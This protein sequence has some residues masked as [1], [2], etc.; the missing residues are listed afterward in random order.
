MTAPSSQD[1]VSPL[2]ANRTSPSVAVWLSGSSPAITQ[3]RSQIRRVAPH[4]RTALLTGERDC[5]ELAAAHILHQLSPRGHHPFRTLTAAD[6]EL[7]FGARTSPQSNSSPNPLPNTAEGMFY[8]PR[9]ERL[10]QAA[11]TGLLRL[12]RERG[13]QAPR[14]IAF[15][16]RGLRPLVTTD[17]FSP[18]LADALGALRIALPSLR[19][20]REDIPDLLTQMLQ[21]FAAQT[22]RTPPQLAPDLLDAAMKLPWL[23]NFVQLQSAV[24]SLMQHADKLVL[25]ADDLQS[26][27]GAVPQPLP[28][29]RHEIRMV[30][31]DNVIKEHV[32]AVLFACNGNKLRTADVLGISRSTLYRMLEAQPTSPSKPQ[33]ASPQKLQMSR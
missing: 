16:E 21:D 15:A 30:S 27:L 10:P 28:L 18:E 8:L 26:V 22:G 7:R 31:L 19:Q 33:P 5:G 14:I 4:F 11:Q 2:E 23:G 32:S 25:H 1:P 12:L 29:N 17:G 24:E 13:S 3:L 20:R 9:P 6:A